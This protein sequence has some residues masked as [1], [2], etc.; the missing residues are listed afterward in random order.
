MPYTQIVVSYFENH[1][2]Q[3]MY[4][5]YILFNNTAGGTYNYHRVLGTVMETL[6]MESNEAKE[7]VLQVGCTD[8][9]TLQPYSQH[10]LGPELT[11]LRP[12]PS[13]PHPPPLHRMPQ[14]TYK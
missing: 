11:E 3:I 8:T 1:K 7:S 2:K 4:E 14:P 6:Q 13:S 5:I 12:F 9:V 10:N